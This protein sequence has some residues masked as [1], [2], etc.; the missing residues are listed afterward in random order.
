MAE[1]LAGKQIRQCGV[2]TSQKGREWF[3]LLERRQADF[4]AEVI[5]KQRLHQ[6]LARKQGSSRE[7][8]TH[9]GRQEA[10]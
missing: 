2:K 7:G 6:A 9:M 3:S 4:S 8:E 1:G 10:V 5:L